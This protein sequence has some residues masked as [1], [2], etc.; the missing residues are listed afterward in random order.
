MFVIY[1]ICTHLSTHPILTDLQKDL[2][3]MLAHDSHTVNACKFKQPL[4][5]QTHL[6][7]DMEHPLQGLACLQF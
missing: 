7:P 4:K 1:C 5:E 6:W 3:Q 2:K